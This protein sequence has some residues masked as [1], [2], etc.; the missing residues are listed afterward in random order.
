VVS[1]TSMPQP[2]PVSRHLLYFCST[3]HGGPPVILQRPQSSVGDNRTVLS[4]S[5][6]NTPRRVR[7]RRGGGEDGN[8]A[9]GARGGTHDVQN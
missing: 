9:R 4:L 7:S 1:S 8:G 5:N 6:L 3:V 2:V